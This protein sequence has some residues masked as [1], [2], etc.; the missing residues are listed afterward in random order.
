ML[1]ELVVMV[2]FCCRCRHRGWTVGTPASS[3]VSACDDGFPLDPN[4]ALGVDFATPKDWMS[5]PSIARSMRY[6]QKGLHFSSYVY[7]IEIAWLHGMGFVRDFFPTRPLVLLCH[8]FHKWLCKNP[9]E[10]GET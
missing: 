3:E 10:G 8:R 1:F 2:C 7:G 5:N 4:A 6:K 9:G